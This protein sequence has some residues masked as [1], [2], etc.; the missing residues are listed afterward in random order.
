MN[1]DSTDSSGESKKRFRIKSDLIQTELALLSSEPIFKY[2]YF[3]HSLWSFKIKGKE[4]KKLST[5]HILDHGPRKII[6]K[7]VL[8]PWPNVKQDW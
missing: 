1:T 7:I 4:N 5:C 3:R 8:I 6:I 2:S